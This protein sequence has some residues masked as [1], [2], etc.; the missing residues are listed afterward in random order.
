MLFRR[1]KLYNTSVFI[2]NRRLFS[3]ADFFIYLCFILILCSRHWVLLI[4]RAKKGTVYV[5][6]P[7][8]GN[9]VVNE[10]AKTW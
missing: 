9:C 3:C 1:V 8:P 7:L 2:N 6:D 10:E 4:V 5:L